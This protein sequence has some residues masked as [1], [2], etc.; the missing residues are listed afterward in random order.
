LA[1]DPFNLD[2]LGDANTATT[3]D[4]HWFAA[5]KTTNVLG[6]NGYFLAYASNMGLIIYNGADYWYSDGPTKS[7][8]DT[9]VNMLNQK[10]D[11]DDLPGTTPISAAYDF[12]QNLNLDNSPTDWAPDPLFSITGCPNMSSSGCAITSLTDVIASYGKYSILPNTSLSIT[13]G[14]VSKYLGLN[15]GTHGKGDSV[16]QIYFEEAVQALNYTIRKNGKI[17]PFKST[18][19]IINDS[20]I[21]AINA[22]LSAGDLVIVGIHVNTP[23]MHFIVIYKGAFPTSDGAPDYYILDPFRN[24]PDKSGTQ[25]SKAYGKGTLKNLIDNLEVV[26]IANEA[27]LANST[28]WTIVAHSPVQMLITDPNGKQTGFNSATGTNLMDIPG[29]NYGIQDPIDDTGTLPLPPSSLNFGQNNLENGTYKVQVIGTGSGPYILDFA[30]AS[31]PGK[32]SLQTVTGTAAPGKTD[33]YIVTVQGGQPIQI[34]P[35]ALSVINSVALNNSTPN[36]GDAILVTVNATDNVGVTKVLANGASLINQGGTIWNGTIIALAGTHQVNVSASDAAGNIAR[37]NS[38]SYTATT[39]KG[40]LNNNGVSA[41][42]GD[43]VLMKRASIGEIPADSSYDLNNNG[44]FAD[45]GDLV[46]MKRASI[47]E[48]NL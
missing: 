22:G 48:I 2:E 27:P 17:M 8:T 19:D 47:G 41:D 21:I 7:L 26:D 40:D 9:F 18:G 33:T 34:Q 25:L 30:T 45:A 37:N 11:P 39:L 5:A 32:T 28:T 42:A 29:S 12:K 31:G 14:N 24:F 44:Q 6:N 36:T 38:T 3:A 15:S 1:S 43:L 20:R 46:L 23:A 4:F 16:C 35:Q 10:Y 13:P